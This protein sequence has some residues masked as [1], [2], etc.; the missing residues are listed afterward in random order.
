MNN[1]LIREGGEYGNVLV[2]GYGSLPNNLV[3]H[4]HTLIHWWID[5]VFF[6]ALIGE[7]LFLCMRL[8]LRETTSHLLKLGYK[9][10]SSDL[11]L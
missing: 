10:P 5:D 7:T 1:V 8:W 4:S 3:S 2:V 11:T 6:P 9:V